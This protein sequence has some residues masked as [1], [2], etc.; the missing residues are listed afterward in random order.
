MQKQK[1]QNTDMQE[2]HRELPAEDIGSLMVKLYDQKTTVEK[3]KE[4]IQ[5]AEEKKAESSISK[6]EDDTYDSGS[7]NTLIDIYKKVEDLK[8]RI[9]DAEASMEVVKRKLCVIIETTVP[10]PG[11]IRIKHTYEKMELLL[12]AEYSETSCTCAIQDISS[13]KRERSS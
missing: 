10:E 11:T 5:D 4:Q 7:V 8:E 13:Q 1:I 3:F 9:A 12:E 2:E 6:N